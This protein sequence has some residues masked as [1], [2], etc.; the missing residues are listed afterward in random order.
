[1]AKILIIEDENGKRAVQ[2]VGADYVP[3][4]N[5]TVVEGDDLSAIESYRMVSHIEKRRPLYPPLEDFADAWVKNDTVALEAY[6]QACLAVKEAVP[7]GTYR[8]EL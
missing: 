5:E 3:Q 8:L 2:F 1:M 6:R 7:K 4:A